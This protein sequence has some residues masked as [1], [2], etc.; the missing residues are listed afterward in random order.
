MLGQHF[1]MEPC[2]IAVVVGRVFDNTG[3][4]MTVEELAKR[5]LVSYARTKQDAKEF[6]DNYTRSTGRKC[7]IVNPTG[8]RARKNTYDMPWQVREKEVRDG[9]E[10][11]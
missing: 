4:T 8:T 10:Q 11:A 6:A 9:S 5:Y 1:I 2:P 7:I 3:G